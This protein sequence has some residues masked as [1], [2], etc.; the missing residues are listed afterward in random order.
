M[1][2]TD[3]ERLTLFAAIQVY[4]T[5]VQNESKNAIFENLNLYWIVNRKTNGYLF[6]ILIFMQI[7]WLMH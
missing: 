6:E 1:Q 5:D 4:D 2:V 7:E 3:N